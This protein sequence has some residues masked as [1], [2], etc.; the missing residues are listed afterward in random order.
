M[1]E[2]EF[3]ALEVNTRLRDKISKILM[4]VE[5]SNCGGHSTDPTHEVN[6]YYREG[7]E[8]HQDFI[9]LYKGNLYF[10]IANHI[11]ELEKV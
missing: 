10:V 2:D 6:C 3:L 11:V 4:T 9:C 1:S 8:I 5:K 7:G